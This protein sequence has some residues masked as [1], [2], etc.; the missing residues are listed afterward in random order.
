MVQLLLLEVTNPSHIA[1]LV[2]IYLHLRVLYTLTTPEG[3]ALVEKI[4]SA[5]LN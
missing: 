4:R 5:T 2:I 3:I 1:K